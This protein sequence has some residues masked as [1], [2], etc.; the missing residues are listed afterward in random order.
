MTP[1]IQ[2]TPE[3]KQQIKLI[4]IP[5]IEWSKLVSN[6]DKAEEA[7]AEHICPCCGRELTNLRYYINSAYGGCVYIPIDES[8]YAD[9]WQMFVGPE[10]MKKFPAGY[11]FDNKQEDDNII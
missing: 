5:T 9:T 1:T 4:D 3:I 10:C 2:I 7:H 8:V 6:R 11:V